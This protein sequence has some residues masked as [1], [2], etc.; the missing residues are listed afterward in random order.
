MDSNDSIH[1]PGIVPDW[2]PSV[3]LME[4]AVHHQDFLSDVFQN[5]RLQDPAV[6]NNAMRRYFYGLS[7]F[8]LPQ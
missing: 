5:P 6:L 2:T 3:S 4:E 7:L 8:V 1:L